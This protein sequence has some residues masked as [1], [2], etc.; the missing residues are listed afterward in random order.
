M[1]ALAV[2]ASAVSYDITPGG[3]PVHMPA[4][5]CVYISKQESLLVAVCAHKPRVCPCV[6][7]SL[8][9]SLC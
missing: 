5:V 1:K 4:C 9:V 8:V 7:S 3:R 2:A 6:W